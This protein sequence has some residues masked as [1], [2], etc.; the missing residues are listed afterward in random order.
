MNKEIFNII[1]YKR[2]VNSIENVDIY[3][4]D[5]KDEVILIFKNNDKAPVIKKLN[6]YRKD[7]ENLLSY[8]NE[9]KN[10]EYQIELYQLD[11]HNL[12]IKYY[13][14]IN[15]TNKQYFAFKGSKPFSQQYYHEIQNILLK[16][17]N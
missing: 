8:L 11:I 1:F 13:I 15:Y 6:T 4:I 10:S 9:Y 5:F 14:I 17:I 3:T 16:I 7:I 2:D 12:N